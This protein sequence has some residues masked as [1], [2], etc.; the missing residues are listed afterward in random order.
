MII[1]KITNQVNNKVYIGQTTQTLGDRWW[2]HCNRSPSQTHRSYIHSAIKQYG[3]DNFT[4]E[5]I[6]AASSIDELNALEEALINQYVSLAPNGYNLHVG[7][8]N[9]KCHPE[10]KA[11]ISQALRGRPIANRQNG[12][13]KGRPVSAE[14]RARISATL[15]GV[16][17]PSKYKAVKVVETGQ[18]FE[19][20]KAACAALKLSRTTVIGLLKSGGQ[21]RAGISFEYLKRHLPKP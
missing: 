8:M 7:G 12:A 9:K 18:V 1:Y 14:R 4:I 3:A 19:S 11:K 6:A 20:V 17:Q 21:S 15:T 10:T 2:Q 16:A 13:A 5:I